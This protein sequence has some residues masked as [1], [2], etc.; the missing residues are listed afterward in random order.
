MQLESILRLSLLFNDDVIIKSATFDDELRRKLD[1][2][3][4]YLEGTR[5]RLYISKSSTEGS[6][7]RHSG[8]ETR[9]SMTVVG[10]RSVV[11][12]FPTP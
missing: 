4:T 11:C 1:H 7:R 3:S 12:K 9:R 6:F 10:A 2:R 8:L 5:S